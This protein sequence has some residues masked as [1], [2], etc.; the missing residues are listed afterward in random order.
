VKLFHLE[1][2]KEA[3]ANFTCAACAESCLK[4]DCQDVVAHSINL[5]LLKCPSD[6]FDVECI[7]PSLPYISGP[8]KDLLVDP[9]G[10]MLTT[11]GDYIL[12][13][14]P[15]CVSALTKN[16]VPPMALAN[17]TFLGNMPDKLKDLTPVEES[18]I[19]RCHAKCWIVQL[20]EENQDLVL[21]HTQQGI[22]GHIII[23]PQWPEHLAN[24]PLPSIEEIITPI[25]VVFV[26][27]SPPT[28][29]GYEKRLN[30]CLS[31]VKKYVLL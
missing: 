28:P 25:C 21:P 18:M 11:V 31:D 14:Y 19:A 5:S 4:K 30:L 9:R 8:L 2:S 23:Y 17:H 3:L 12:S 20:K 22:K 26:G 15:V 7:P 13:L 16:K 29:N 27:S 10:V 24:V 1:T 6:Y